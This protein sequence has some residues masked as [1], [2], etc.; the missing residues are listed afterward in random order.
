[1]NKELEQKF[2]ERWPKW[3]DVKGDIQHTLMPFGFACGD[4]WFDL[5]WKLCEDIEKILPGKLEHVEAA[6]DKEKL[7]EIACSYR[8]NLERTNRG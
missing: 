2:T 1:M 5:L 6:L 7:F 4:G 8:Y 3:F